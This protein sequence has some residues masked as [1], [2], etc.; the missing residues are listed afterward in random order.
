[1]MEGTCEQELPVADPFP[2][3]R[4]A[5]A[6]RY[7][8]ERELG[9]G[10][11]AT[12][13]LAHDLKHRRPVA[14][15]VLAPEL[16]AALG[17]ERFLREIET[18]ASL[19]HPHILP[20]HDSGEADGFLYY[21]MPYVPGESLRER[22]NREKQ[23]PIEHA[24]T[25]VGEVANALSY[26]HSRDVV[27]RDVKPENI[28]LS[29]GQAIVADFGIAGAIDAAGGGK[30]TRTGIVLGTPAY[31]SPEQGAGER[32]LDGRSDVYS[33]G[34]LLYEMLAGEPPFT[35]PTAQAIIAKRFT[36]P[37][38]SIRRLRETVP[39]PMDQA[40]A[41]ALARAPA[42][43]FA[44][45]HQFAEA[46]RASAEA[47]S[48]AV[49]APTAATP[50]G[51]E[52]REAGRNAFSRHSWHEAFETLSNAQ[53]MRPLSPEDVER[54][55]ESA[56]WIGRVD[57]SIA[58]HERAYAAYMDQ[59]T[60]RRAAIVAVRL[61]ED[62]FN[63]QAK[64]I[65]NG[66]LKRAERLLQDV[67]ECLEHGVLLRLHAVLALE[68]EGNVDKALG[69]A[70]RSCDLATR[71]H[72]RDLQALAMHDIG[73]MLVSKGDLAQGMALIDEAM[74]TA[75]SGEL[76]PRVTGRIYCNMMGTCEKLADYQRAAEWSEAARRWCEPHA[77]SGYPGI[78]R[79]HRAELMRLRGSWN[80]AE[81]EAL[82]A[83]Q[84]LRGFYNIAAG[85]AF[86]EI[87][88]IR[89]RMGDLK[90]AEEVLR[91]AHELGREPV[92]G[93]ALLRL[94]EGK[95]DAARGLIDRAVTD[96]PEGSLDR[97]RLLPAR[98]QIALA[99]GELE[100]ARG[101]A[102]E[103]EAIAR[104][105]GSTALHAS[106]AQARGAVQLAEGRADGA[107]PSLRRACKL[108]QEVQLP[109]ETA[110]AR[111]LLAA[112]YRATGCPDDAELERQAA[113]STFTS[114]GADLATASA[115]SG[116]ALS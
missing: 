87:G 64:S 92:P 52:E 21:V 63:R 67:P 95:I 91:Q 27:H 73:R 74:A 45:P 55:A 9:R 25:I 32:A 14:I 88:E 77:G 105:Y 94:A 112:A 22:L 104:E 98:V 76:G 62:F 103:L 56:W 114:L 30:L 82:R 75:V 70:R 107:V 90:R 13:Y 41:K 49:A 71:F 58:A 40:I 38:P 69:F 47:R 81:T 3:L 65:G 106:A 8:I 15:K 57:D 29:D 53:A 10:G 48:D 6:D 35:G 93:L 36:D 68:S 85:E 17:R 60:P 5:L 26:A 80:D 116:Q 16:S 28:L 51:E 84:E 100:V 33:L 46:L 50:A 79:V 96:R 86:Y 54:L 31:M 37:V 66:W 43:R 109:Y 111:A 23:L 101:T 83:S 4:A 20:L 11:M 18:A 61:A 78:C 108:W 19:S 72:D 1:M 39:V 7:A 99:A 42:D 102:T 24:V 59:G 34:C 44:T 110:T 115:L 89:L 113:T 12:V 2:Q 97:A